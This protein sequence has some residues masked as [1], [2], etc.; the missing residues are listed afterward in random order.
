MSSRIK[1]FSVSYFLPFLVK[2]V[3]V[4]ECEEIENLLQYLS[5]EHTEAKM[6]KQVMS[7]KMS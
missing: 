5:E 4:E 6:K 2:E 7:L 1:I 3:S